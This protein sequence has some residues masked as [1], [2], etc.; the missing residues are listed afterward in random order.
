[1][2]TLKKVGGG[3]WRFASKPAKTLRPTVAQQGARLR[4]REAERM[5]R[6][7]GVRVAAT[8]DRTER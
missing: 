3:R 7:T 6:G 1:M 8:T 4:V 2:L 5:R